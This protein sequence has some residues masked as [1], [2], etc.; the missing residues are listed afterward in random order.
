MFNRL[1]TI[2]AVSWI[3][4]KEYPI[5]VSIHTE[6]FIVWNTYIIFPI[7]VYYLIENKKKVSPGLEPGTSRVLG[8]RDNHYTTKPLL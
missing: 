6:K 4:Q 1:A 8:E 3:S 7:I 2:R 5:E